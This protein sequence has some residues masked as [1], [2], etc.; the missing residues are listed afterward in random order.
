MNMVFF[1]F[2]ALILILAIGIRYVSYALDGM[3]SSKL[4][5]T[6]F[7][8]VMFA[9]S[10]MVYSALMIEYRSREPRR[11]YSFHPSAGNYGIDWPEPNAVFTICCFATLLGIIIL[12][13]DLILSY[14][15]RRSNLKSKEA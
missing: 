5:N 6:G 11:Y 2:V 15:R 9:L 8:L 1:L 14:F 7:L 4:G 3:I 13:F 10:V 12:L